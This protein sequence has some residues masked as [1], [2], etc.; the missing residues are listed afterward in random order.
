MRPDSPGHTAPESPEVAGARLVK[1]FRAQ[2]ACYET[3]LALAREQKTLIASGETEGLMDILA[4][5]QRLIA[6]IE[7][8]QVMIRPSKILWDEQGETW[9]E[10]LRAPVE[11]VVQDLRRV[12]GEIVALEDAVREELG[13]AT[14]RTGQKITQ[15]QKGKAMHKAYGGS[16]KPPVS[17]PHFKDRNA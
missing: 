11:A 5:K 13:D 2:L 8:M 16:A 12:L 1:G 14:Q 3:V 17:K 6:D 9:P 10:S 4:R 7:G 15:M